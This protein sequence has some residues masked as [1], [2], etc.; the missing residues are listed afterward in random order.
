MGKVVGKQLEKEE[1]S[2]KELKSTFSGV[3]E[4][5]KKMSD[6]IRSMLSYAR[7]GSRDPMTQVNVAQL[8]KLVKE[9]FITSVK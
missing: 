9:L 5:T 8:I 1:V 6:I 2:L 4:K 7:D 3:V